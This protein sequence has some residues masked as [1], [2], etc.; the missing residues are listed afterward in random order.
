MSP[1]SFA[2]LCRLRKMMLDDILNP[3]WVYNDDGSMTR[4][5]V[6]PEASEALR[7]IEGRLLERARA[8]GSE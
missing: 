8:G 5:D 1:S 4:M 7:L 3:R 2:E 6:P